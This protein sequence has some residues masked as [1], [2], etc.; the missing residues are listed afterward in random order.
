MHIQSNTN[1]LPVN[2]KVT[3]CAAT[4]QQALNQLAE[5]NSELSKNLVNK[6][7]E[8]D[9]AKAC[10]WSLEHELAQTKEE[11][12]KVPSLTQKVAQMETA[13][14]STRAELERAI[15]GKKEAEE[16]KSQLQ[17]TVNER[18]E[19]IR[20]HQDSVQESKMELENEKKKVADLL[21]KLNKAKLEVQ[22]IKD[23]PQTPTPQRSAP[24]PS[25]NRRMGISPIPHTPL[26]INSFDLTPDII[27]SVEAKHHL[28]SQ[29]TMSSPAIPSPLSRLSLPPANSSPGNSS[30]FGRLSM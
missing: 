11:A 12:A 30:Q 16:Q 4:Y 14:T 15:E 27:R 21:R 6:Q 9:A 20:W 13:I 17:K 24:K 7:T 18:N 28:A 5:A 3:E 1:T 2:E 8:L 10:G 23:Q 26:Q 25:S 19:Q 22:A 29:N